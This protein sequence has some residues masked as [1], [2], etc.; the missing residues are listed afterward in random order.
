M[1]K[2]F[3]VCLVLCLALFAA[4]SLGAFAQSAGTSRLAYVADAAGILNAG[5]RESLESAAAEI[6]ERYGCG[7]YVVTVED[8]TELGAYSAASASEAVYDYYGLGLGADRNA[9]ILFLS[10]EDR[11]YDLCAHGSI[12]NAAFTDYGKDALEDCFLDDFS[13]DDWY[14]GFN[15][16]ISQCGRYLELNAQGTPVDLG[17]EPMDP[18]AKALLV[19]V[20]PC[21]I[22]LVVCLIFRSQMKTARRQTQARNYI[23]QG[24]VDMRVVQD[25]F[26]HRTQTVQVI[27][28]DNNRGPRIG[29]GGTTINSGGF[30]HRS[31]KF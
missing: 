17:S 3:F 30:S 18:A 16:Y 8:M 19:V 20:P 4:L 26:T 10:M 11:D 15:D 2:R 7:V 28:T 9:I 5:Q 14:E 21:V 24:G 12:G 23:G 13:Y 1:K 22:A 29:G 25:H 31:G 6:S 27:Q